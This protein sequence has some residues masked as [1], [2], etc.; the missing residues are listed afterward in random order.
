MSSPAPLLPST[1]RQ[2]RGD[3]A[4]EVIHIP[5]EATKGDGAEPVAPP[6]IDADDPDHRVNPLLAVVIGMAV[7]FGA[8]ALL[9][10]LG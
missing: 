8:L 6:D 5:S 2:G 9:L 3:S 1:I 7:M 10:A 4:R